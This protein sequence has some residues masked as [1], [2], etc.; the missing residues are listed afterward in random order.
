MSVTVPHTIDWTENGPELA[1]KIEENFQELSRQSIALTSGS[2]VD[3]ILILDSLSP[4]AS[5][6]AFS[7]SS[8]EFLDGSG[9][10]S[11]PAGSGGGFTRIT[12]TDTGTQNNWAPG[13]S[14]N[15]IIEWSGASDMTVT[16]IA[17]GTTAQIIEFKNT[18]SKNAFFS[19]NSGSSSAGNKLF[20]AATSAGTPV[21]P[22]GSIGYYYDGTQWQLLHHDQGS[23]I[24]PSYSAGDFTANGSMTWG[25]DSGDVQ[26]M[27]YWLNGR[28]LTVRIAIVSTD[29]GGTANSTLLIS[30]NQ[31]GGF[32]IA[33][34][35]AHFWGTLV[36]NAGTATTGRIRADTADSTHILFQLTA[37]GNW[38]LT[39]GDNTQVHGDITLNVT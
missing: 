10:W 18:G 16:G 26:D 6:L 31:W 38:T 25:V 24:T 21:A 17:S 37:A 1:S 34:G 39:S 33:G 27:E 19:H 7:G 28:N 15:T 22:K 20:N 35:N 9:N 32:T 23:W 12:S 30:N 13:L 8:S 3:G 36:V 4:K 14:D 5:T 2:E 11:T 29:V